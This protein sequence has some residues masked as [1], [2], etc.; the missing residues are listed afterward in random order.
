[1]SVRSDP[2]NHFEG[3]ITYF[4]LKKVKIAYFLNICVSIINFGIIVINYSVET[5]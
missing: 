1:M 4:H 3:K 2:F 5:V